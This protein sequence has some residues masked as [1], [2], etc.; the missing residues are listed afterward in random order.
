M[1]RTIAKSSQSLQ[2]ASLLC[3][4]VSGCVPQL[5]PHALQRHPNLHC[6]RCRHGTLEFSAGVV[7][8]ARVLAREPRVIAEVWH[9]ER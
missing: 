6:R 8:L 5:A 3:A 1:A 2:P 4:L 7:Q 9:K